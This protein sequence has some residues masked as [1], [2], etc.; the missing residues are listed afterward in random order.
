MCQ[1]VQFLFDGKTRETHFTHHHAHLPVMTRQ[2]SALLLPWGRRKH[3]TCDLP[4]GGWARLQN[5]QGGRWEKYAARPVKLPIT[6]FMEL[7]INRSSHWSPVTAGQYL[8]GLIAE[9]RSERRVY[10]VTL[11]VS[12]DEL[13]FERWP[14]IISSL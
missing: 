10:I 14:R 11:E 5:I 7:D 12:P 1:A 13:Y 6:A 2:S 4:F 9:S 8:Q 3:E